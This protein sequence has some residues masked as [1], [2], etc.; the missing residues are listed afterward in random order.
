MV[1][2]PKVS[3]NQSP[4][5]KREEQAE[6]TYLFVGHLVADLDDIRSHTILKNFD[7]LRSLHGISVPIRNGVESG[8]RLTGTLRERSFMRSRALRIEAGS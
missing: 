5:L 7:G 8:A 3:C 6:G 2:V 4:I 1:W